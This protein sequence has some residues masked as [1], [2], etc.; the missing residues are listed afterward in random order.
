MEASITNSL[1]AIILQAKREDLFRLTLE[2]YSRFEV[3][4]PPL[5]FQAICDSIQHEVPASFDDIELSPN[6][7]REDKLA[8]FLCNMTPNRI[9]WIEEVKGIRWDEIGWRSSAAQLFMTAESRGISGT[10]SFA[11]LAAS[12]ALQGFL[13]PKD[14]NTLLWAAKRNCQEQVKE[15][16]KAEKRREAEMKNKP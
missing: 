2:S 4:A 5:S 10:V 13:V 8:D 3:D 1:L 9:E 7:E 14:L 15:L 11:V 16:A 12:M 6:H